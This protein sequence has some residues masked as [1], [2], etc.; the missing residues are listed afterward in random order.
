MEAMKSPRKAKL[1]KTKS[2][3]C[4]SFQLHKSQQTIFSGIIHDVIDFTE[5]KLA[6]YIGGINEPQ[7]MEKLNLLLQDYLDGKVA[8]AWNKGEPI[9]IPI[10]K[11]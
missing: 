5:H 6:K 8:V 11:G 3:E 7:E 1:A 2:G 10:V 4:T 9:S